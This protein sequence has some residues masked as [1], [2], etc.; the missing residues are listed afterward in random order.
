MRVLYHLW[1]SPP[2]RLARLL[3]AE[4][5]VRFELKAEKIWERRPAFLRLSPAGEVPVLIESEGFALTGVHAIAEHLE[6]AYKKPALYGEGARSR[7]EVRRLVDW[8]MLKFEAEAAGP[9]LHETIMKR[10]A[11]KGMPSEAALRAARTNLKHHLAYIA[12]LLKA[13]PYLAGG[14]C[15]AA[16]F[17]ASAS[18]SALDYLG[19]V[20]WHEAG[21]VKGWYA[22]LKARAAFRALLKD[23]VVGMPPPPHYTRIDF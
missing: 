5:K 14:E 23:H 22:R 18:L 15:T 20:P 4:K 19:E 10:Y 8:F 2:C 12:H 7:A 11:R 17:A 16:D 1:L 3:L 6:E 9:L 13:N 21:A